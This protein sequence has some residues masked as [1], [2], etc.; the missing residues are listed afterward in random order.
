MIKEGKAAMGKLKGPASERSK[1]GGESD[2]G[3]MDKAAKKK[4][5]ARDEG[6]KLHTRSYRLPRKV[7]TRI[8]FFGCKQRIDCWK[9]N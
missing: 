1:A 4:W 2:G 3:R 7:L 5:D 6:T 8:R 9:A